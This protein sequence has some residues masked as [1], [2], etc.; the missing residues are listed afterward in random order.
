MLMR[1]AAPP[2]ILTNSAFLG[3][4]SASN[5]G[6]ASGV[7]WANWTGGTGGTSELRIVLDTTGG[8]GTWTSTWY[9]KRPTD[10]TY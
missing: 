8:P 1:G 6:T 9:A 4:G 3:N 10:A 5:G 7:V 2:T